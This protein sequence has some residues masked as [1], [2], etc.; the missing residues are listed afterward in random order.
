MFEHFLKMLGFKPEHIDEVITQIKLMAALVTESVK[1]SSAQRND[2]AFMAA[3]YR[4]QIM[5]HALSSPDDNDAHLIDAYYPVQNPL[6]TD[7]GFNQPDPAPDVNVETI[8][9]ESVE[10]ATIEPSTVA[11]QIAAN[12][13]E[14]NPNIGKS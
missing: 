8:K 4:A 14:G 5:R 3:Y 6:P 13:S 9:A 11:Q 7:G 12:M 10:L 2:I 1:E